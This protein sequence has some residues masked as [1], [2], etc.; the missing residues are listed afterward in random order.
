MA[1]LREGAVSYERGTS[2]EEMKHDLVT[3]IEA[4]VADEAQDELF[5]PSSHTGV[6]RS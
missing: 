6:P 1:V 5:F 3:K 4:F 2:E